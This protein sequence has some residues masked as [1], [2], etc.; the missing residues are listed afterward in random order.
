MKTFNFT[1][2]IGNKSGSFSVD[3]YSQ[4]IALQVANLLAVDRSGTK[5]SKLVVRLSGVQNWI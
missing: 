3:A 5:S 1:W 4:A 2:S